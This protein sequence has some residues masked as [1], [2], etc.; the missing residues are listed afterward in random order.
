MV[1]ENKTGIRS[2]LFVNTKKIKLT[3]PKAGVIAA[4]LLL[5]FGVFHHKGEGRKPSAPRV[6]ITR[7]V[8]KDVPVYLSAIGTVTPLRSITVRPQVSGE[9]LAVHFSEGAVVSKGDVLAEID[10]RPYEALVKQYEG[11]L[12]KDEAQLETARLDLMRDERLYK[13]N[14]VAEQVLTNQRV[15][16]KQYEGILASDQGLLDGAQI[17]LERCKIQ[18]PVDGQIG[19][20]LV[21][22]GNVVDSTSTN[23]LFVLNTLTPTGVAFSTPEENVQILKNAA[24]Q[25][26]IRVDVFD[27]ASDTPLASTHN[28]FLDNQID[29][30]TGTLKC[31]ALFENKD[32]KLFANQFVRVRL[33]TQTLKNALVIPTTAIG[34]GPKGDYVYRLINNKVALTPIVTSHNT[35]DESVVTK[36]LTPQDMIVREGLDKLSQ[37]AVV[38]VAKGT[39]K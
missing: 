20:V 22:P 39:H 24:Q 1:Q 4:L 33:L 11:Q 18:A 35:G 37:G 21:D 5:G 28:L 36:G 30:A 12:A 23:G 38:E 6:I 2:V 16:V 10:P 8:H 26:L 14:V 7:A 27:R 32:Q 3:W 29:L 19:L 17:N 15:L 31:R 34:H 9:L 13:T 25:G